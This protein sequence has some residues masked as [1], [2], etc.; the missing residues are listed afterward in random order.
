MNKIK[1]PLCAQLC[2]NYTIL[3]N[4]NALV[5]MLCIDICSFSSDVDKMTMNPKHDLT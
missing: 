3:I 5:K 4:K 2:L 1:Q